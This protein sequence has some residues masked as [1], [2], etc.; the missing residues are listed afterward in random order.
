MSKYSHNA[1][2]L[3]SVDYRKTANDRRGEY[4]HNAILAIDVIFAKREY[5]SH[6]S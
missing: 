2:I 1:I 5:P 6:R 3:A 4:S